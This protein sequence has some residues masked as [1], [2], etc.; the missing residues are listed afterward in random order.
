M[1]VRVDLLKMAEK[2]TIYSSKLKHTGVFNFPDLYKF[3]YEWLTQETDLDLI[4]N[5]YTEKI[6]GTAKKVEAEWVGVRKV[7]DYFKY[8]I[9][10][11]PFKVD[12]MTEVEVMK[13]GAKIKTNKG[14]LEMQVKGTLIR[15]Y[16]GKFEGNAFKKFLRS[17]YEKWVIKANIDKFEEML[18]IDCDTFLGQ[19]KAYLALEGMR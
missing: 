5:K 9:K 7:T 19:V 1:S 3:C 8:E 11:K 6:A 14:M 18:I 15:D 17:I 16:D 12:N 2:Q 4:E 13:D 10:V